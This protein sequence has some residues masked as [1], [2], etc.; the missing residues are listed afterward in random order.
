MSMNQYGFHEYGLIVDN[1]IAAHLILAHFTNK[2][3]TTDDVIKALSDAGFDDAADI[4][5]KN[6]IN[7]YIKAAEK[8]LLS[9]SAIDVNEFDAAS[10]I[11][12]DKLIVT[13]AYADYTVINSEETHSLQD[14]FVMVILLNNEISPFKQAYKDKTEMMHEIRERLLKGGIT[15]ISDETISKRIVE[16]FGTYS[17]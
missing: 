8:G 16:L 14:A 9:I 12:G 4:I 1:T 11:P 13:D 2:E 6:G 17:A 10:E 5:R 15:S 7:A 3:Q